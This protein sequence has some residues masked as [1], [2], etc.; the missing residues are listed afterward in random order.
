M[1]LSSGLTLTVNCDTILIVIRL[2]GDCYI[3]K[4][5]AL[6]ALCMV[7]VFALSGCGDNVTLTEEQNDMIAEY[8][9]GS[10][11][12]H[13]YDNEWKYTK[14]NSSNTGHTSSLGNASST[15][16]WYDDSN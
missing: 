8:V 16:A 11:L 6:A 4:R 15:A 12:K 10:L 2:N 7:G 3:M 1:V 9:A 14:L 13:S 5:L